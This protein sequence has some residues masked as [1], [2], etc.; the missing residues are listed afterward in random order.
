MSSFYDAMGRV[1]ALVGACIQDD[2]MT[3]IL[4]WQEV[5]TVAGA[6]RTVR[7]NDAGD[8]VLT[9]M[10]HAW[11]DDRDWTLV[12]IHLSAL[13]SFTTATVSFAAVTYGLD[14]VEF[15][16]LQDWLPPAVIALVCASIGLDRLAVHDTICSVVEDR[17]NLWPT[18]DAL[19]DLSAGSIAAIAHRSKQSQMSMLQRFAARSRALMLE[20]DQL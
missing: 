9:V 18:L 12:R 16:Q 4:I 6:A 10:E 19:V 11:D 14:P 3:Q 13:A 20:V 1:V 7:A 5:G 15:L 17:Q 2:T 8:D